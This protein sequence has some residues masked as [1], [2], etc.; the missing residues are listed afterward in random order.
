MTDLFNNPEHRRRKKLSVGQE[1]LVD[2]A[3]AWEEEFKERTGGA[4]YL[5]IWNGKDAKF[6]AELAST[7]LSWD[8]YI[9]RRNLYFKNAEWW[10]LCRCGFAAFVTNI[11]KF[12][13]TKVIPTKGSVHGTPEPLR[14][15]DYT[16]DE[17][18]RVEAGEL[19]VICFPVCG[20]C[21]YQHMKAES[22]NEHKERIGWI[23]KTFG[24]STKRSGEIKSL[25]EHLSGEKS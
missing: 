14:P 21:G 9:E 23:Q 20:E 10:E 25:G 11:N 22:C 13:P 5:I 24:A 15:K 7:G 16:D 2:F 4:R 1:F 12:V 8:E 17:G 19:C 6:A 3:K 18:H